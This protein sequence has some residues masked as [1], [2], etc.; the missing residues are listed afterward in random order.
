MPS[1]D[2]KRLRQALQTR[3]LGQRCRYFPVLPS[4]NTTAHLLGRQGEPE[5]TMVLA[6]AQTG[7]RGQGSKVW[8]SPPER[9]LYVSLL[10]RPSLAPAQGPLISL[11]AAVAL[12]DTLRQEGIACGIKW[13]NDVLIHARKVAGILTEMELQG[14]VVQFVVVGIGVNVNMTPGELDRELG[15]IA[16]TATSLQATLGHEMSREVLL[17]S[18]LGSLEHWYERF[19]TEGSAPLLEAWQARS[20]MPGRRVSARTP[21]A[22]WEGTVVGITQAGHLLLRDVDGAQRTLTSAEVRFLD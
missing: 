2:V 15:P 20:L 1:F 11:V 5:G 8:I 6:D 16:P 13:P 10:L 18:L 9:N 14:D 17:A 3:M 21:D 4:T 22:L 7:G 19:C 12:V